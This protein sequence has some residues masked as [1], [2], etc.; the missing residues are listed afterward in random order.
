MLSGDAVVLP[1]RHPRLPVG[2]HADHRPGARLRHRPRRLRGADGRAGGSKD[3]FAGSGEKAVGDVYLQLLGASSGSTE[4]LGYEGEGH[5]GEGTRPRHRQGRRGGAAGAARAT[6]V[7]LVA[8]PHALLRRVRRPGG[9]HRP[10]RGPRRQGGGAGAGRAAAGAGLIVHK[11]K[12]DAGHASSRATWCSWR[13][14][15]SGAS[16]SAPT[17]RR[18]TCCTRRSSSC[19]A[20]T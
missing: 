1:P 20:T 5:E 11:V 19:S 6:T 14:T 12:V 15:S 9:R 8:R 17:T 10:D 18:R 16:P 2:P 3:K 4:F 13:W 7:E